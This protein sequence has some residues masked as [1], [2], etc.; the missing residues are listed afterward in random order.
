[1]KLRNPA[2]LRSWAL[3]IGG[4]VLLLVAYFTLPLDAFGPARPVFSWIMF[5]TAITALA[6]LLLRKMWQMLTQTGGR[7]GVGLV[8]LIELSMVVF[9]AT[10]FALDHEFSG[11]HTRLD[12]LYFTVV[13]MATVGYGDITPTSQTA[14]LLVTVQI[15]Y[16]FVFLAT[17]AGTVSTRVRSRVGSRVESG[18]RASEG[19]DG[20]G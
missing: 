20:D 19:P 3:L 7:P 6:G 8:F 12:A 5:G 17:A 1:V 15:F 14:R 4:L 16:N 18:R 2:A 11:L 9:S 10:Y 13:T